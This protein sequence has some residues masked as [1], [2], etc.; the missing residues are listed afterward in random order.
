MHL[1]LVAP[2]YPGDATDDPPLRFD[3]HHQLSTGIGAIPLAAMFG[4]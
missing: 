2:R 3:R 4:I 1:G